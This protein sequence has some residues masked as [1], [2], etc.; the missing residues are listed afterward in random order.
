MTTWVS[1]FFTKAYQHL[2]SKRCRRSLK[3]SWS[4][5]KK[6]MKRI[7][8]ILQ[9]NIK[10]WFLSFRCLKN[11]FENTFWQLSINMSVSVSQVCKFKKT[12]SKNSFKMK[13]IG[14][15][16]WSYFWWNDLSQSLTS[17]LPK[18]RKLLQIYQQ[19]SLKI[20]TKRSKLQTSS[21]TKTNTRRSKVCT[22][23]A[24]RNH[25]SKTDELLP[26]NSKSCQMRKKTKSFKSFSAR[27]Q[28]W[29]TTKT[30]RFFSN[31][32]TIWRTWISMELRLESFRQQ[33]SFNFR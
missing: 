1:T 32:K 27:L 3:S 21:K 10:V 33:T 5:S 8:V 23:R 6:W 19:S 9:V 12:C 16:D 20:R 4:S 31:I 22:R 28:H 26:K 25:W 30:R 14:F 7:H 17:K 15:I 13:S 24:N 18:Q 29:C 11:R 2:C